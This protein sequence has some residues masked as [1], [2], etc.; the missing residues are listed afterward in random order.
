MYMVQKL[1][2]FPTTYEY[3]IGKYDNLKE[4]FVRGDVDIS[5]NIEMSGNINTNGNINFNNGT[6]NFIFDDYDNDNSVSRQNVFL[7]AGTS[8][9]DPKFEHKIVQ[10]ID[11]VLDIDTYEI[12]PLSDIGTPGNNAKERLRFGGYQ[13]RFKEVQIIA[14]DGVKI[15]AEH[16]TQNTLGNVECNII[17]CGEILASGSITANSFIGDGSL[18]T[19]LPSVIPSLIGNSGKYLTT[20]GTNLSWANVSSS[21]GGSVTTGIVG[22]IYYDGVAQNTINNNNLTAT[23]QASGIYNITFTTARSNVNYLV[24]GQIIE[25]SSTRDDIKIHVEDGSQTINGFTVY[26]YEGDNGGSPDT[27]QDRKFYLTIIDDITTNSGS[28]NIANLTG[29]ASFNNVD[30]SG[31]LVAST[32]NLDTLTVTGALGLGMTP[33][34]G[35]SGSILTNNGSGSSPI[36]TEPYYF[37][38]DITANQSVPSDAQVKI[39]FV[40]YLPSPYNGNNGDMTAGSW[41]CPT[42]GLYK[43]SLRVI[44]STAGDDIRSADI[45]IISNDG[46]DT[47]ESG[48]KYFNN[49]NDDIQVGTLACESLIPLSSGNTIRGEG[50]IVISSGGGGQFEKSATAGG[51]GTELVI[52]R[53]I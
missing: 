27:H 10:E 23:R 18:L 31:T 20:D 9:S 3:S 49:A 12:A 14:Q 2:L 13:K 21:G 6:I 28:G 37:G 35:S 43:V 22:Y 15:W 44:V 50:R 19:N 4:M 1:E 51:K 47:Y 52:T 11:G 39:N 26:I 17:N 32:A 36:W 30:I 38:A 33:D 8:A 40:A 16:S 34:Y 24:F 25:P 29:D 46:S 48:A 5:G 42:D 53:I 41:T 7:T 45:Y